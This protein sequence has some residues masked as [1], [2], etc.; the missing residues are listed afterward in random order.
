M[1]KRFLQ[2]S[3]R[4]FFIVSIPESASLSLPRMHLRT[5]AARITSG[6]EVVD[7][8]TL[9]VSSSNGARMAIVVSSKVHWLAVSVVGRS[10]SAT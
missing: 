6:M 4:D 10:W 2:A 9:L 8:L 3:R 5:V 1:L 7:E